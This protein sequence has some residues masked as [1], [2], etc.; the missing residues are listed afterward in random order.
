MTELDLD[1]IALRYTVAENPKDKASGGSFWHPIALQKLTVVSE[2][3]F[4][5]DW[6]IFLILQDY[7]QPSSRTSPDEAVEKTIALFPEGFSDLRSVND[8]CLEL[9]E[10]IPYHHPSQLKLVQLLWLIG[11][12]QT[13]IKKCAMQV[14]YP[15][16]HLHFRISDPGSRIKQRHSMHS[17][18]T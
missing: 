10:Q 2:G 11:R 15:S 12:N 6:K 13:R 9:A 1:I 16:P 7:L 3:Y 17:I 8:V 5:T 14:S 18:S 4:P